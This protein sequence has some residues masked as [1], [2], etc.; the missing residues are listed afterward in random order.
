MFDIPLTSATSQYSTY[1]WTV[2]TMFVK[3]IWQGK[4]PHIRR[5]LLQQ[6]KPKF[7]VGLPDPDSYY[8]ALHMTR[9]IDWCRH[10]S[11]QFLVSLEQTTITFPP[12]GLPWSGPHHLSV[13]CSHALLGPI[14]LALEQILQAGSNF[15]FPITTDENSR[16]PSVCFALRFID[17]VFWLQIGFS[18]YVW[19]QL[20]K[21]FYF[22]LSLPW[23]G[24][25]SFN[26]PT[27]YIPYP[28]LHDFVDA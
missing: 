2:R 10:A 27:F 4:W 3:Y 8:I 18:T 25:D 6:P 12:V 23:T 28:N 14:L 20:S 9:V 11:N 22:P 16:P 26:S 13:F 1:F 21:L 19:A 17:K 15:K 5:T 24:G 7:W